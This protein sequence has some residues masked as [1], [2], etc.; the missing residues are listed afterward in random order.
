M[1]IIPL[2]L[3]QP[4]CSLV[5]NS[6]IGLDGSVSESTKAESTFKKFS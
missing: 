2:K 5:R 3:Q 6:T 4:T 1:Y